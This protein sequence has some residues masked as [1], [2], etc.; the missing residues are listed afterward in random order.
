MWQ[1]GSRNGGFPSHCGQVATLLWAVGSLVRL[2]AAGQ[3]WD[4]IWIL[5]HSGGGA[6]WRLDWMA[7]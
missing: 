5:D 1:A 2:L 4:P 6:M 3:G 7:G